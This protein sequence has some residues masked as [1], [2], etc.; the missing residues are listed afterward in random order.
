MSLPAYKRT[1]A[2]T[3]YVRNVCGRRGL[4][5]IKSES[6]EAKNK[7]QET[8]YTDVTKRSFRP[9]HYSQEH[10]LVLEMRVSFT[11]EHPTNIS[12]RAIGQRN[13]SKHRRLVRARGVCETRVSLPGIPRQEC[14][15]ST[16]CTIGNCNTDI[17][18]CP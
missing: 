9:V 13:L 16:K 4:A 15:A 12:I 17:G 1:T 18:H 11:W 7:L 3:E 2:S 5:K 8:A 10:F 6:T 14:H